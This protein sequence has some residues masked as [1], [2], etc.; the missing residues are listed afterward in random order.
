MKYKNMEFDDYLNGSPF[1]EIQSGRLDWTIADEG[2][3]AA[4]VVIWGVLFHVDAWEVNERGEALDL[5]GA[6]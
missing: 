6:A 1:A 2:H 5:L 4:T 3:L